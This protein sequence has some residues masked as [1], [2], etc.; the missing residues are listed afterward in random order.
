MEGKRER[1]R[2]GSNL[3]KQGHDSSV[4]SNS[5]KEKRARH[6][7]LNESNSRHTRTLT[8]IAS[9]THT[10][11]N[12]LVDVELTKMNDSFAL[13]APKILTKIGTSVTPQI[14]VLDAEHSKAS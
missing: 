11:E 14:Q 6:S 10:N 4:S 13:K 8:K 9:H 1:S 2:E 5:S 7:L 3:S 12:Y